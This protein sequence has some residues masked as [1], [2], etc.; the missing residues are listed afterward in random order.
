MKQKAIKQFMFLINTTLNK[1]KSL[2]NLY[3]YEQF[4]YKKEASK[5]IEYLLNSNLSSSL[6][7]YDFMKEF[8]PETLMNKNLQ[9]KPFLDF[10]N[11]FNKENTLLYYSLK[12]AKKIMQQEPSY[13][14][15]NKIFS[16][17][18]K[19]KEIKQISTNVNDQ[20]F[21]YKIFSYN[22]EK[23]IVKRIDLNDL[24]SKLDRYIKKENPGFK[25]NIKY[26]GLVNKC[27]VYLSLL[28]LK[29]DNQQKH[30]YKSQTII[31]VYFYVLNYILEK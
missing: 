19:E 20:Y 21:E 13:S 17:N 28:P 7:L 15:L 8:I 9:F 22:P 11:Y 30:F 10:I 6:E 14:F 12:K 4:E 25:L 27:P 3:M 1:H 16:I 29:K 23:N 26:V 24:Y 2:E 31:D 5:S 18:I